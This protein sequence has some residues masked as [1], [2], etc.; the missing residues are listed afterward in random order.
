MA[1]RISI[2]ISESFDDGSTTEN[3]T[4]VYSD[5][6]DKFLS[7]DV[8]LNAM[9]QGFNGGGFSYIE[10]LVAVKSDGEEVSSM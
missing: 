4:N 7:V 2:S 5:S 6:P 9:L 1:Y 8:V 3:T 10:Q